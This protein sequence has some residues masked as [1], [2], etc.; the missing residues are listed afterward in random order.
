M[1]LPPSDTAREPLHTR[2]IRVQSYA[3]ADGLWDLEAEL[4]DVK[5]YDFET[6]RGTHRAGVPVHGILLRVTIND[7]YTIVAAHA[8]YDNAPY[9]TCTAIAPDYAGLVGMN[10]LRGFRHKVKER[11]GRT[12][13]CTHLT[14]LTWVLPTAA[15]QSMS[16]R[17]AAARRSNPG[18]RPFQLDGCHALA[19]SG[20]VVEEQYPQWFV[21][22]E[23]SASRSGE[24]QPDVARPEGAGAPTFSLTH[25][26]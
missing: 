11:F 18:E 16:S 15:V 5:S 7:D 14:E 6:R 17:R 9:E 3:R 20:P 2:S 13:G 24:V 4:V 8:A 25:T 1:P 26:T 21:A 22:A 19:V 10:L 23:S 12:A